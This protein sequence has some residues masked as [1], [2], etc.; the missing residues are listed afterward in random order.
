MSI[1]SNCAWDNAFCQKCGSRLENVALVPKHEAFAPDHSHF[2]HGKVVNGAG[3][4][5]TT[6]GLL[7][8]HVKA[9]FPL[10][11][12]REK[13]TDTLCAINREA[14]LKK[15]VFELKDELERYQEFW[16]RAAA[17]VGLQ[18]PPRLVDD[19]P[20]ERQYMHQGHGFDDG[21]REFKEEDVL[22]YLRSIRRR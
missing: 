13:T 15:Q 5:E 9:G 12:D 8:K 2:E 3:H 14:E 21:W 18:H 11:D 22:N 10:K 20:P 19:I 7:E 16:E 6:P 4:H 1:C 17:A